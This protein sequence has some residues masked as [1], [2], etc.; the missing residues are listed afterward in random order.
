LIVMA[1]GRLPASIRDQAGGWKALAAARRV[2]AVPRP[3]RR[4][5]RKLRPRAETVQSPEKR[6]AAS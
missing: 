5:S 4:Q 2:G 1:S 6:V 3:L